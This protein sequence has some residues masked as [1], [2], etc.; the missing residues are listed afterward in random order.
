MYLH[1]ALRL[2]KKAQDVVRMCAGLQTSVVCGGALS[3]QVRG[4]RAAK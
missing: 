4:V 2:G 1:S 3:D